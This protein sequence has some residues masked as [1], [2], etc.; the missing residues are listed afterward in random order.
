[1][2]PMGSL[3]SGLPSPGTI[4]KGYYNIVIDMKD[5]FFTTPLHPKDCERFAFSVPSVNFKEPM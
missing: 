4:P 5:Y 2:L 1:M 3:Q